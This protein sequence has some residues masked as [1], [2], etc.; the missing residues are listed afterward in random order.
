MTRSSFSFSGAALLTD[1]CRGGFQFYA[2]KADIPLNKYNLNEEYNNMRAKSGRAPDHNVE[3]YRKMYYRVDEMC[4]RHEKHVQGQGNFY[5]P[6]LDYPSYR[7][8]HPLYSAEQLRLH[9]GRHHRAYVS[10]LNDL[11]AGTQ[12]EGM[13]LD[14][15]LRRTEDDPAHTAIFNNA[16][17]HFNHM[18]FWKSI[19]PYGTNIPPELK[20]ALEQQY[21]S[22]EDFT[23]QVTEKAMGFF[24]SGWLWLVWNANTLN[25]DI[26]TTQNAK[27]AITMQGF[28][29]LLT[30][31]LWEHSWA[32]DYE[33]VKAE[34]VANYFKVVDWHWAERHWKRSQGKVYHDM[35]WN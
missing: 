10:K 4:R 20:A 17:Q 16:A 6:A 15:I 27:S 25:F 32:K 18:F 11:I 24:G 34:Y 23:K 5:L 28:T 29:P 3:Q 14:E 1:S 26:V 2:P 22:M 33:N 31:D 13:P 19:K 30:M 9:Y 7:G 21:G 12:F 35:V 8:C